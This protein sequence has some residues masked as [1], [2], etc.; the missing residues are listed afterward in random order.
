MTKHEKNED[1]SATK[2]PSRGIELTMGLTIL[3]FKDKLYF[4]RM[5]NSDQEGGI[6]LPDRAIE[7]CEW[8]EL[9][10][11]APQC[12]YVTQDDIGKIAKLPY[13]HNNLHRL[14][15]ILEDVNGELV[16]PEE[17]V[18]SEESFYEEVGYLVDVES[19]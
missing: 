10:G 1:S 9:I 15:Y 17:W 2:T 16:D 5:K 18:F 8:N 6:L 14:G 11:V 3:P 13:R 4:R 12:K 7:A 19:I